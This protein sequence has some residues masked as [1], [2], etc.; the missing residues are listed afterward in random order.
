[1]QN[2]ADEIHFDCPKCKR[3][4]SGDKAL[5]G[6]IINCPD[7]GDAFTPTPR[8]PAPEPTQEISRQAEPLAPKTEQK[9]SRV[10]AELV[11]LAALGSGLSFGREFGFSYLVFIIGFSLLVFAFIK[12]LWC[13]WRMKPRLLPW[14]ILAIGVAGFFG[15]RSWQESHNGY[16]SYAQKLA[17]Y[18]AG[19]E[20]AVRVACTNQVTG[21]RQL[22][23]MDVSTYDQNVKRWTATATVEYVNNLGGID[24]TN[25]EFEFDAWGGE[26][27]C[28]KKE[29]PLFRPH[30]TGPPA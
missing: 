6:E 8:K 20:Q 9:K 15:F 22:I 24:R 16:V 12:G 3:P 30:G 27:S 4:M 5:L 26:L 10:W 14:I 17:R 2:D 19:A 21:L 7:C 25:L 29:P 23:R 28:F 1:M 13:V 18:R 11:V